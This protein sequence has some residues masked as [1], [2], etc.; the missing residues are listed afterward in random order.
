MDR[1]CPTRHRNIRLDTLRGRKRSPEHQYFDA[2]TGQYCRLRSSSRDC[3]SISKRRIRLLAIP[4]MRILFV[5]AIVFSL[6][7]LPGVLSSSFYLPSI[8]V[9][10]ALHQTGYGSWYPAGAQEMTMTISQ[11]DGVP[12]TQVDW[13]T[14]NQVDAEDWPLTANQYNLVNCPGSTTIECSH[15]VA[16]KGYFEI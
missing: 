5:F 15:P 12:Q 7:S 14:T 10:R 3:S 6:A 11:G 16:D 9:V 4:V 13:L 1:H 2:S 8:P